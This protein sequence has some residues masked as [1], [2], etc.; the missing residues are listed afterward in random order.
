MTTSTDMSR[1]AIADAPDSPLL[2]SR[3]GV[4]RIPSFNNSPVEKNGSASSKKKATKA[5]KNLP[6]RNRVHNSQLDH[7]GISRDLQVAYG[8]IEY[9]VHH[10]K[11]VDDSQKVSDDWMF[12]ATVLD[13]MFLLLFT[14][15]LVVL[16]FAVFFNPVMNY[17]T[18]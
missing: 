3:R 11:S 8:C 18:S 15:L 6:N 12:V 16:T 9:V 1:H 17:Y 13:R 14:S 4:S 7:M 5:E 2:A 10:L